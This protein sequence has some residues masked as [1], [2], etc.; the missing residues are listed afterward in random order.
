[1]GWWPFGKKKKETVRYVAPSSLTY[2]ELTA[3]YFLMDRPQQL[4]VLFYLGVS[5]EE[6]MILHPGIEPF[7]DVEPIIGR[8]QDIEPITAEMFMDNMKAMI[9]QGREQ[10]LIGV[11]QNLFMDLK[12][13]RLYVAEVARW[14]AELKND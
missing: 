7:K 2:Q 9:L 6:Q 10:H 13:G 4:Q 1:M 8:M 12:K 5:H 11:L 14:P 3:H